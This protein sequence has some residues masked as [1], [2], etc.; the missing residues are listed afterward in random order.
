MPICRKAA[1]GA[2]WLRKVATSRSASLVSSTKPAGSIKRFGTNR[3]NP[4]WLDDNTLV[5][6]GVKTCQCEGLDYTGLNWSL[7]LSTG[8]T[9]RIAVNPSDADV[10]R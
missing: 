6:T 1:P 10:L 7:T 2:P 4:F 9:R 8:K 5:I 3:G